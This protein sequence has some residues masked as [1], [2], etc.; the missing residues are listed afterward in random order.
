MYHPNLG[1]LVKSL[2]NYMKYF[3]RCS[4]YLSNTYSINKPELSK[5][6]YFPF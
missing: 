6:F 2:D 3:F 1:Y 5:I 4:L